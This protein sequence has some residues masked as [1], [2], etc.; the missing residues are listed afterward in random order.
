MHMA[1]TCWVWIQWWR[2]PFSMSQR[3][4]ANQSCKRGLG[5]AIRTEWTLPRC[6]SQDSGVQKPAHTD[7]YP[8]WGLFLR[9]DLQAI[10]TFW[11]LE[12]KPWCLC[13]S[14]AIPC[15]LPI[16][17][18]CPK[19]KYLVKL[20]WLHLPLPL[21]ELSGGRGKLGFP[22]FSLTGV[23]GEECTTPTMSAEEEGHTQFVDEAL[24]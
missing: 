3:P 2:I 19:L 20:C 21:E 4:Q 24:L 22:A 5:V 12:P 10:S 11:E 14:I 13:F 6:S 8:H 23:D 16:L 17:F 9:W 7:W 18:L 1:R 15:F